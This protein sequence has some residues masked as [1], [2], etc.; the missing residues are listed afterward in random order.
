MCFYANFGRHFL[1]SNNVGRYFYP[2]FQGFCPDFQQTK[3]FGG[4]LATP[5]PHTPTSNN[6]A[7]HNSIIGNFMVYQDRLETN[8]LQ[9]FRHPENSE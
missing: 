6:T 7:F 9:L 4:A 2:D 8:L 5:S 1:K 3:T